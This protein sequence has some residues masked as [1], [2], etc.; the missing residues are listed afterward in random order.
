[1]SR[2]WVAAALVSGIPAGAAAGGVVIGSG[3]VAAPFSLAC[4]ATAL[5]AVLAV[6]VRDQDVRS[7][8]STPA[9]S[10]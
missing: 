7:R 1:M 2:S 3:G 4:A 10:S 5:A 9:R 8:S 6:R